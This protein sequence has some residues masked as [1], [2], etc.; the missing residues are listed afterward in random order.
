LGFASVHPFGDYASD[1]RLIEDPLRFAG[2]RE[3][4]LGD[5]PRRIHWKATAR[6]HT[7][8]SKLY[9]PS[10][11]RRLL[12]LLDAW[13]Y[14]ED[15]KEADVEIQELTISVAASLALWG[16]DNSYMVGLLSNSSLMTSQTERPVS[17]LSESLVEWDI[18][19]LEN[20]TS[21][22]ISA[23]GVSVP[24]ASDYGQYERILSHLARLVPRF[25]TP[26]EHIMDTE[27]TMFP[28]G[29]TVVLVSAKTSLNAATIE[30]LLD[31]RARGAAVY[32]VLTGEPDVDLATDIYDLPL[33]YVGGK[34]K[35]HELIST[36]GEQKSETV[37]TSS[38][39]LQL[40]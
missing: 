28:L 30:R 39:A 40:D 31:L 19:R 37:G 27:D 26:I 18:K 9:E 23:P 21:I 15:L 11:L 16:L 4:Q 25:N 22:K 33:H 1:R 34:E 35:W 24:F 36:V 12:V 17:S 38:T 29:T 13:N 32:L 20:A 8:Q 5:D 2:V 3:Y 6:T 7:L 10:S 14:S